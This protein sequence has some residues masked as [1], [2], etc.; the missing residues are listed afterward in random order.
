[1]ARLLFRDSQGR[2]GTVELSPT[3]TVYV[4]RGL[5][6][7]IR[8]DDGMVSRRHSQIRMENGRFVVE[9]LGSANG[10]HLNN[11]ARSRS[12]RSVTPTSI[13]CGSLDDPLHRRG[14]RQR[15]R[16]SSPARVAPCPPKKGG[17]MVLERN[18]APPLPGAGPATGGFGGPPAMFAPARSGG[19]G[20]ARPGVR[21]GPP[22]MPGGSRR[23]ATGR[24][25]T[26]WLRLGTAG[27]RRSARQVRRASGIGGPPGCRGV[28]SR[29]VRAALGRASDRPAVRRRSQ[30]ARPNC[31]TVVRRGCPA[32][33][34][35]AAAS[36]FGDRGGVGGSA[37][38]RDRRRA[39]HAVWRPARDARCG[40]APGGARPEC[41]AGGAL[42]WCRRRA[43]RR[44]GGARACRTRRSAGMPGRGCRP[45]HVVRRCG[46][47]S[48]RRE[49]GAR[50]SRP[51]VR[52]R[53][54][55]TARSRACAPS[56]RR[57]TANY[58]R[59]VADGKRIRAEA[60]TLR[61][62]IE[63]L[64]RAVKDREEQVAAHDRVADE[65]RDEL[66]QTRN[67]LAK[68]AQR[69]GRDGGEHGGA[70]APGG[71]CRRGHVARSARTWRT[72]TAS[73]WSCRGRR[74]RAGR[75]STSSS[76]RS[77]TCAR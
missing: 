29:Q 62:R 43:R 75:S 5:E 20:G 22:A 74:T 1:M 31:R 68:L 9:D 39:R 65:L 37:G 40:A 19:F 59:E 23:C 13:Q 14:R 61:E 73:S 34:A 26:R 64:R 71:A 21:S 70:R 4:G 10:T 76:P 45:R 32:A 15:R 6:C 55:P 33:A 66:Q 24:R 53:R 35:A 49:Q 56:S 38:A 7:A 52:C 8:T 2:E 51:R 63:E 30:V 3:E 77:S 46:G 25:A 44:A 69:D 47:R 57:P 48:R 18:D 17:T 50:R 12:R 36:A 72:S 67:E 16:R 60:A 41:R 27:I 11:I 42:R 58:E 28:A 54:R